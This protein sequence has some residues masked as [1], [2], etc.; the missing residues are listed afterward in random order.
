[1][2]YRIVIYL[3][4]LITKLYSAKKMKSLNY[5][6]VIYALKY[7]CLENNFLLISFNFINESSLISFNKLK[8]HSIFRISYFSYDEKN[9]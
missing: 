4:S 8:I 6:G 1:M 3:G 9:K 7:T 2:L 5:A